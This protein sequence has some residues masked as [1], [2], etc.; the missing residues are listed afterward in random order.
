LEVA[1]RTAGQIAEAIEA[2]GREGAAA[3]GIFAQRLDDEMEK[4]API[5]KGMKAA[6]AQAAKKAAMA[7]RRRRGGARE[8]WEE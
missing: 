2:A 1:E 8:H 7:K 6:Q 3:L 4:L 5:V